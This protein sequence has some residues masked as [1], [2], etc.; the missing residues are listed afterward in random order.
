MVHDNFQKFQYAWEEVE[1]EVTL[2]IWWEK[3][4]GGNNKK[5]YRI[6][7]GLMMHTGEVLLIMGAGLSWKEETN[8]ARLIKKS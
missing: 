6:H 3:Q 8:F 1:R 4:E 5:H 2:G 7:F